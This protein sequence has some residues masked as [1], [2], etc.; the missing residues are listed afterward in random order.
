MGPSYEEL[1]ETV[2]RLEARVLD[3]E[4]R[5]HELLL[6]WNRERV[7]AK[8]ARREL[9]YLK[10]I[11]HMEKGYRFCAGK[12]VETLFSDR[13]IIKL[14]FTD[15]SQAYQPRESTGDSWVCVGNQ[16]QDKEAPK[17]PLEEP[18]PA[19]AREPDWSKAPWWA[20]WWAVDSDGEAC[21]F[22]ERPTLDKDGI[23]IWTPTGKYEP[24]PGYLPEPKDPKSTLRER[25]EPPGESE[26]GP[27]GILPCPTM[28]KKKFKEMQDAVFPSS[29]PKDEFTPN[30]SKAPEGYRWL[31]VHVWGGMSW[32]RF[33]PV[34]D[35][36]KGL[37]QENHK[38]KAA[39]VYY[40]KYPGD[41][42]PPE[43][44]KTLLF[45]RP[46]KTK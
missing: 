16:W 17:E 31:A 8:D 13:S 19:P 4:H 38:D 14:T 2:E 12:T 41:P 1:I 25:P 15:G 18:P 10:G 35:R 45:K 42:V 40:C 6:R 11:M 22:D 44:A 30:W 27:C 37:W 20:N 26:D 24:I 46:R 36:S 32:F 28:S 39:S 9:E 34:F 21:W 3:L 33:K 43:V 5:E 7:S 29:P 23:W